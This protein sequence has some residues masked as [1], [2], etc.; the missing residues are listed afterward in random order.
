MKAMRRFLRGE[1]GQDL[2]EYTLL[3][4]FVAVG[5]AAIFM[6][7]GTSTKPIWSSVSAELSSAASVVTPPQPQRERDRREGHD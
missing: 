3:V 6:D 7:V 4:A 2:V 5:S 1:S